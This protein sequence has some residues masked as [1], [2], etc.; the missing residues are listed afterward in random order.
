MENSSNRFLEKKFNVL[1]YETNCNLDLKIN[2]LC[3]WFSE[4]AWKHAKQLNLGFE[5]LK[6][7]DYFWVLF[8][9]D[10]KIDKLP[11][12]Q[13]EVILKTYPSGITDFYFEREFFLTD[14]DGKFLAGAS[15]IWLIINRKNRRIVIPRGEMFE[16]YNFITQRVVP[17]KFSKLKAQI[18]F[19]DCY[20]ITT[21]Y[22]ETDLH[23]HINNAVYVSWIEEVL[24]QT[25]KIKNIKIQFIKELVADE[26]I[27][28]KYIK[29][30]NIYYFEGIIEKDLKPCYRAEVEVV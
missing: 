22:I 13:E 15:S 17:E 29:I 20:K 4:I 26:K 23:L 10:I 16:N 25:E 6:E 1:S 14:S 8:G 30:D 3:Q 9:M 19:K 2:S 27:E 21:R 28:L 18:D 12:W 11:K 24:R 7:S 5:D